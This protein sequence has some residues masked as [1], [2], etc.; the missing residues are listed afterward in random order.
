MVGTLSAATRLVR[1]SYEYVTPSAY[2]TM[3]PC[4]LH[5]N[6]HGPATASLAECWKLR[7]TLGLSP[8]A[9]GMLHTRRSPS[10]VC[11]A[12]MSDFCLLLLPCQARQLIVAGARCVLRVCRMV[13]VGC[14]DTT[15]MVPFMY[16]TANVRQ[17]GDGASA[18]MGSYIVR[19]DTFSLVMGWK[20][21]MLPCELPVVISLA[22]AQ[23]QRHLPKATIPFRIHAATNISSYGSTRCSCSP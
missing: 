13:K 7:I 12:S 4:L 14:S 9:L 19:T 16:P 3:R 18:V 15:R 8:C 6:Q 21:V 1:T 2:C 20:S 5:A 10:T 11:V 17:S 23:C 22:R